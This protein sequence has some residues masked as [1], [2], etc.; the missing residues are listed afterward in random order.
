MI[1][2]VLFRYQDCPTSVT[3]RLLEIILDICPTTHDNDI[4]RFSRWM[5]AILR[6]LLHR[7]AVDDDYAAFTYVSRALQVLKTPLGKTAYPIDEAHWLVATAW[8][9]GLEWFNSSRVQQ[10]K[11]WCE[12][13]MSMSSYSPDLKVDRQKMHEHYE[14]LLDKMSN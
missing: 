10:A 3:Y 5:R 7:N 11:Q 13:A 14:H 6:I 8:N 2:N 1:A 12:A 9:R 4:Q